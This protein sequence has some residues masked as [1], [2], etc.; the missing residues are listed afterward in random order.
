MNDLGEDTEAHAAKLIEVVILQCQ[1]HVAVV[2]H[3]FSLHK[4]D[5]FLIFSG[6]S[7]YRSINCSTFST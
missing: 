7:S 4:I 6:T 3:F 5:L 2:S 1:D